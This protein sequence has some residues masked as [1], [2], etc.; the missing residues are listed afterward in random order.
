MLPC[1]ACLRGMGMGSWSRC[2]C[3]RPRDVCAELLLCGRGVEGLLLEEAEQRVVGD[4][5]EVGREHLTELLELALLVRGEEVERR[6]LD[7]G[8]LALVDGHGEWKEEGG[9]RQ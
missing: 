6:L 9:G 5:V 7:A 2:F 1:T 4:V 8:M 3:C